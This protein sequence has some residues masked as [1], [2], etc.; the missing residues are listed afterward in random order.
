MKTIKRAV[1]ALASLFGVGGILDAKLEFSDGQ[2]IAAGITNSTN[3]INFGSAINGAGVGRGTPVYLNV[4]VNTGFTGAVTG[5][6]VTYLQTSANGTTWASGIRFASMTAS[7]LATAGVTIVRVALPA[8][9]LAQ[10]LSLAFDSGPAVIG[11]VDAWLSLE[12][13]TAPLDTKTYGWSG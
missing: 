11:A 9:D 10:Y 12:A 5:T 3:I 8:H 4:T 13:P 6:F 7:N 2:S 1:T